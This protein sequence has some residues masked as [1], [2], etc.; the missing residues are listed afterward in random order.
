MRM[1]KVSKYSLAI[2]IMHYCIV[3]FIQ[4]RQLYVLSYY[5]YRSDGLFINK[6]LLLYYF[7][8]PGLWFTIVE[9]VWFHCEVTHMRIIG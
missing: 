8:Q 5:N 1:Q 2:K 9:W 4:W 7:V 6:I 3:Y